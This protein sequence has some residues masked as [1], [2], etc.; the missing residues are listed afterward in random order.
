[1]TWT[2]THP[3]S[4][5]LLTFFKRS[6]KFPKISPYPKKHKMHVNFSLPLAWTSTT[7]I[8]LLQNNW[9]TENAFLLFP[10]QRWCYAIGTGSWWRLN[11]VQNSK[12][13]FEA[14]WYV[15]DFCF[16]NN[17]FKSLQIHLCQCCVLQTVMSSYIIKRSASVFVWGCEI[18]VKV[19]ACWSESHRSVWEKAHLLCSCAMQ[20][21]REVR[22]GTDRKMICNILP[23]LCALRAT[24][25]PQ[26][27][28][29]LHYVRVENWNLLRNDFDTTLYLSL[30]LGAFP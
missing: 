1:M 15:C 17:Y 11:N 18:S 30:N 19:N 27:V 4:P 22:E 24:Y 20:R 12:L 26:T 14:S 28:I 5:S 21:L 8:S 29:F 10:G 7:L 9:F 2:S 16:V 13:F 3:F 6:G 25:G 23:L